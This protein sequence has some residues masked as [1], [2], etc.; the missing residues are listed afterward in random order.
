MDN[1][2]DFPTK[3]FSPF[4]TMYLEFVGGLTVQKIV[5]DWKKEE[6]SKYNKFVVTKEHAQNTHPEYNKFAYTLVFYGRPLLSAISKY[7]HVVYWS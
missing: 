3:Y 5:I 1:K 6:P 7:V 2:F 4:K